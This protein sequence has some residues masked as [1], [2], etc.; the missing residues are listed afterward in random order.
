VVNVDQPLDFEPIIRM[1]QQVEPALRGAGFAAAFEPI[2]KSI[3]VERL[4]EPLRS[5]TLATQTVQQNLVLAYWD[6][7]LRLSPEELQA[8]VDETA[9]RITVPYL[10]V[11]GHRL[12]DEE[13]MRLQGRLCGLELEEWPDRGHMVHLMEPDRFAQRLAAFVGR[14]SGV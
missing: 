2:R 4:P 13:R 7:P 8:Q 5:R 10:A 12:A 3:G 6:E 14:C 9:Q 1:L 11:F